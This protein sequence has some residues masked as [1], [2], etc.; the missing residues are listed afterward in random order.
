[1]VNQK[2]RMIELS[3][4]FIDNGIHVVALDPG[5]KYPTYKNWQKGRLSKEQMN[6]AIKKGYG[7]GIVPHGDFVVVDIDNDHKDGSNGLGYYKITYPN[8]D[9]LTAYKEGSKNEHRF[10]Q[11]TYSL[12]VKLVS[13]E[14]IM[15]GVEIFTKNQQITTMPFYEFDNL[16]LNVP[17]LEQLADSPADFNQLHQ[18]ERKQRY[19]K[20]SNFT[21]H[22]IK[23]YLAKIEPFSVG[24]R[25]ESYRKLVFT[26]VVKNNMPYEDVRDAIIEWDAD[27]IDYQGE[28]PYQFEH[29]IRE[30]K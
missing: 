15:P 4:Y 27:T 30:P 20:Q 22:N 3:N 17:F 19:T 25:S 12:N 2:E 5:K 9:T 8:S 13:N 23:N 11:N 6:R 10:Y 21:N 18:Y 26:M 1:M 29:S 16:D 7:V 14:A 28:E 24:S